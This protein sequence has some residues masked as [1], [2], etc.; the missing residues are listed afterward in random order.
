MEDDDTPH[1]ALPLTVNVTVFE[2][3]IEIL[4]SALKEID[5]I[6][7]VAPRTIVDGFPQDAAEYVKKG[8]AIETTLLGAL[9]LHDTTQQSRFVLRSGI[10]V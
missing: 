7:T 8:F 3:T 5:G 4:V 2:S 9:Q 6:A 1:N 10:H